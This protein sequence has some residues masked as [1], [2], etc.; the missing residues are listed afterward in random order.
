MLLLAASHIKFVQ[1]IQLQLQYSSLLSAKIIQ[2]HAN[3]HYSSIFEYILF[4][5]L[6]HSK[7][8][9]YFNNIS[10]TYTFLKFIHN[11]LLSNKSL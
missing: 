5:F 4:I 1:S 8:I 3:T 2:K 9:K 11:T 6:M 7:V 10:C